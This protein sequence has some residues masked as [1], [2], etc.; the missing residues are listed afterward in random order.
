MMN[1]LNIAR[2]RAVSSSTVENQL[3]TR[4]RE[5]AK[6]EEQLTTGKR[7]NRASDDASAYAQSRKLEVLDERY[8]QHTR[9]IDAARLWVNQ[10]EHALDEMGELFMQAREHS[11]RALSDTYSQEE[12]NIEADYLETLLTQMV[13]LMNSKSGD[14]Y[15]FAGSRTTVAPFDPTGAAVVYNGNDAQRQRRVGLE[16]AM[17]INVTG[18]DLHDT[19]AGFTIT[20]AMQRMIDGMRAGDRDEMEAAMGE[21]QTSHE[22]VQSLTSRTGAVGNRLSLVQAQ[23]DEAQMMLR[24]RASEIRDIDVAEAILRYQKEQTGLQATLKV[25]A[26]LMQTTLLDYLP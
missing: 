23:I 22:H 19:G 9:A 2:E 4:Q 16:T 26:S 20:D 24:S 21:I 12:R 13:D 15:L 7:V 10:T 1:S 25:T 3:Y 11:T 18:S 6:L 8:S 14:E 5:L 17:S